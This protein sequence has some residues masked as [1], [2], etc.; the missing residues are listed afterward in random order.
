MKRLLMATTALML[1]GAGAQAQN[2]GVSLPNFDNT[3]QTVIKN[4]MVEH[5][6]RMDG[7]QLQLEDAQ[8][9]IGRQLS[10]VQNFI[11]SGVDAIIVSVVDSDATTAMSAAAA[12]AGV[13]LIYV[14]TGPSDPTILPAGQAF[15]A[16]NELD[17]GRIQTEE[18]C[19]L[20][21]AEGKGD[22]ATAVIIIGD[23]SNEA[24]RLRAQDMR[25]VVATPDCAFIEIIEGQAANW[26][27]TLAA[28]LVTNWAS[29]GLEYDAIIASNDEMAIGAIQALKALGVPMD[30]VVIGGIDAT[31]DGLAAMQ[32]G[33]LDVTVF[34]DGAGQGRQ[35]IDTALKILE[36]EAVDQQIYI[37]FELV[38]PADMADFSNLN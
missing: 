27:R 17:S 10:Q 7:V 16:S 24:A 5:A 12:E 20:L 31:A 35:S 13:P 28:D 19:R 8:L 4:A 38:T 2:I 25:D 30:Q 11:A 18:I 26:Q 32:A 36:G 21:K 23:L 9:D 14:N 33:D 29:A 6:A 37:P 15:V 22:G 3:F 34:Q 1:A